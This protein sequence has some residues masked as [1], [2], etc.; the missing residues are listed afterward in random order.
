M[1][2][3]KILHMNGGI[4]DSS[5]AKNSLLQQK[6]I[7]M[8]KS[9]TD[10]A[11][12]AL[13]NNIFPREIIRIAD[14]GCSSGPNTFLT[15]T[16]LIK[17]IDKERKKKGH[18]SLEFL[19]FL[20]DLPSNDFNRIFRSLSTFYEEDLRKYNM[21]R[22]ELFVAGVAGSF[23]TRLFPSNSLHFIHSSY[24]LHWLSQVPDGIENNKGNI[25][26]TSTSPPNVVKGYYEQYERDFVTFLTYRSKEL[27]KNGRM[28]LTMLG[29]K[30]KDRYSK[31]CS[32]EWELLAMTL[33]FF[34]AQGSID[35]KKVNSFN[36][37][38]YNPSPK[39]VMYIVEKEGSFTIDILKTSKIH[40]NSCDDEKYNMILMTMYSLR[41]KKIYLD[42]KY[43]DQ[44]NITK[45][46]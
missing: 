15:I 24:S 11:I 25:Y 13:Y 16:E 33:N 19:I 8:T 34:I 4:G 28:V 42:S 9:I 37:P 1:E 46:E 43:E 22:D 38:L 5:Y 32:Y 7:L 12:S 40:R 2:V 44:T 26:L 18:K 10:E 39:E 45:N 31:G 36:I 27:V 35:E 21:G 23:Y 14:L 17:T 41:P 20:N 30:N 3:A 29:R 6:V